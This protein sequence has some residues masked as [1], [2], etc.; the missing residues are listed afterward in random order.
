MD[1]VLHFSCDDVAELD[2]SIQ[3]KLH[4]VFL[5]MT[6]KGFEVHNCKIGDPGYGQTAIY[7][8][9]LKV[10]SFQDKLAAEV[11]VAGFQ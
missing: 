7:L 3:E 9:P 11:F 6:L 4:R 10:H 1:I 8:Y 2:R 5:I